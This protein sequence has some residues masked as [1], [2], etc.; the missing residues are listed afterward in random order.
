MLA[1]LILSALLR[2]PALDVLSVEPGETVR[3][4]L[5]LIRGTASGDDVI[6]GTS[7]KAMTRF[8]ASAGRFS[9]AVE[10]RPGPNFVLVQSGRD[11]VK[12]QVVYRP[13]KTPY[14]VRAVLVVA[15]DEDPDPQA[16]K[17]LDLALRMLQSVCAESMREAGHGRKTFPLE[18]GPDGRVV[19]HTVRS[20]ATGDSLR[21]R[22]PGALWDGLDAE[23]AKAFD[24]GVDKVAGVMAFARFDP[25]SKAN[26]GEADL[27]AGGLALVGGDSMRRWP[28]TL[29]EI[30]RLFA[31]A[32][33][34]DPAAEAD[35][36]GLRGTAWA[37]TATG[38]GSLL[39]ELGHTFGLA[40]STDV[41][42]AMLRG[43][44]ALNRR[45][46]AVEPPR[47]DDPLARPVTWEDATHWDASE[48]ARLSLSP[49]F[50]PDG[51]HGLR[52]PSALPPRVSL[53]GGDVVVSASYGLGFVGATGA[54]REFK[55]A[56]TARLRRSDLGS[57]P[58]VAV[59]LNGNEATTP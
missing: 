27:G 12:V 51:Y 10:L 34:I 18:L 50:Q 26:L 28:T 19:V 38:M 11:L 39:H 47:R 8:P 20:E 36:T 32:T 59:D 2:S 23:M 22:T 56:K 53:E 49:W 46:V 15:K 14:R 7:W 21:S 40:H 13:M 5:L 42:S 58:V 57:G 44:D 1:P 54:F 35:A 43:F 41:R 37:A 4:P 6:A 30:P 52:F 16:A 55:G 48:A 17:R 31:D 24:Y 3:Y 33:P 29:A 25:R 45:F 9:A